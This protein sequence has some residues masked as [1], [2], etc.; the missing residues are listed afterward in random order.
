[1]DGDRRVTDTA[2]LRYVL[3]HIACV[4]ASHGC[5]GGGWGEEV[6]G[7]WNLRGRRTKTGG[8]V[9][10]LPGCQIGRRNGSSGDWR[11]RGTWC[12]A[13]TGGAG[14]QDVDA[15]V[16]VVAVLRASGWT[17]RLGGVVGPEVVDGVLAGIDVVIVDRIGVVSR[18]KPCEIGAVGDELP[19]LPVG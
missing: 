10:G 8:A 6:E 1:R 9:A 17:R 18:A 15:G 12:G 3:A 13:P 2:A 4:A 7:S 19:L 14:A 5:P 16:A 11:R